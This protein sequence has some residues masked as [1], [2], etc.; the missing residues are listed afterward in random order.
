MP[1]SWSNVILIVAAGAG[2]RLHSPQPK[3]FLTLHNIPLWLFSSL[4]FATHLTISRFILVVPP[5]FFSMP[6]SLQYSHPFFS[7]TYLH[8][9]NP[10]FHKFT[11]QLNNRINIA[12][13][14]VPGGKERHDS[15]W[16]G[17]QHIYS[18]LSKE[19]AT[20]TTLWIHDAARPFLT[21]DVISHLQ[22][23]RDSNPHQAYFP[24]LP[25][26]D[27]LRHQLNSASKTVPRDQFQLVQTPQIFPFLP[28]FSAYASSTSFYNI[29]DD[30]TLFELQNESAKPVPGNR[31]L[32]K[33]TYPEDLLLASA[34]AP[35][36]FDQFILPH[37]HK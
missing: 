17:V 2:T 27:T 10:S 19:E 29:T 32:F 14:V 9:P 30:V 7:L 5:S 18:L 23:A 37:L 34:F 8:S 22:N 25:V 15:V 16:N 1:S 36:F 35:T 33:I 3:A 21:P 26:S 12:L 24:Q 28:L 20:I 11:L 4:S 31:L 6:E 13:H